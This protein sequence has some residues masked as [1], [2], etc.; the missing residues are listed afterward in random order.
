MTLLYVQQY[1][2]SCIIKLSHICSGTATAELCRQFWNI[3]CILRRRSAKYR[4]SLASCY[5]ALVKK[6]P[7]YTL[8]TASSTLCDNMWRTELCGLVNKTSGATAS[9][10]VLKYQRC[11]LAGDFKNQIAAIA[12]L[13]PW[14]FY[15][16]NITFIMHVSLNK[17][18]IATIFIFRIT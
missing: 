7:M 15:T 18:C 11:Q 2:N 1:C 16:R 14:S 5:L 17:K 9:S 8:R 13:P 4:I 12:S 10:G 3:G 6:I